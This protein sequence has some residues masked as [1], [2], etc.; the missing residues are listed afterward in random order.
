MK[1]TFL[2]GALGLAFMG[3]LQA[4]I[5]F[6]DNFSTYNAAALNG[7]GT[8]TNNSSSAGLGACA[9]AICSGA[10]VANRTM[11]YTDYASTTKAV[12]IQSDAD[13][14]GT[15]FPAVQNSGDLYFSFL[16]NLSA[17][18]GTTS[19]ND[20]IRVSSANN[21][22]TTFRVFFKTASTGS[23]YIGVTKGSSGNPAV[24]SPNGYNMNQDHLVVIKYSQ[25]TGTSDDAVSVFVDPVLASAEPTTPAF[26]NFTGADQ[27][28][29][30]DRIVVRQNASNLPT[31]FFSC[32]K[33]ARTWNDLNTL[34]NQIFESKTVQ[35]ARYDLVQGQLTFDSTQLISQAEVTIYDLKGAKMVAKTIDIDGQTTM[36]IPAISAAGVYVLE[37]K[38][39]GQP[40]LNQKLVVQ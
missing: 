30:I 13:S 6:Q 27:A 34:S 1:K 4:Q 10:A 37:V 38:Q 7:Q 26:V 29:S 2:F 40:V 18:P 39:Q 9:G 33:I 17:T 21:F 15:F 11:S 19:S 36:S 35:L 12:T 22:N 32:L 31:G 25:G 8:W 28:G 3:Q 24:F 5:I 14:C 23:Y 20:I 16:I